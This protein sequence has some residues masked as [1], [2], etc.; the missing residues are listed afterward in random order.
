M[1]TN[2]GSITN[3]VCTGLEWTQSRLEVKEIG[4]RPHYFKKNHQDEH[5][6]ERQMRICFRLLSRVM[7]PNGRACFV[8]GRSIIHGRRIDNVELLVRA[9]TPY[10]F[11]VEAII[12]REILKTRKSFNPSHGKINQEHLIVF[13]LSDINEY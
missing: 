7:I 3:I 2:I 12:E 6:F 9:A 10:G 11:T 8:I 13:T 4:A 1:H 5:D